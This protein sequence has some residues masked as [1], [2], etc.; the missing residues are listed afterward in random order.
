MS[1]SFL[2]VPGR[3][4]NIFHLLSTVLPCQFPNN[5]F[6]LSCNPFFL[7]KS[8]TSFY[9]WI[10]F[11]FLFLHQKILWLLEQYISSFYLIDIP[12]GIAQQK[13]IIV[14]SSRDFYTI[15]KWKFSCD[16]YRNSCISISLGDTTTKFKP[17]THLNSKPKHR[18]YILSV[19][20]SASN[21]L[22]ISPVL[23]NCSYIHSSPEEF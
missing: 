5:L 16:L 11:F 7:H 13:Q 12:A 3:N 14:N 22:Q 15:F 4:V 1:S 20:G 19:E 18:K 2:A 8:F 6:M 17:R 21:S 23:G 9:T 10:F